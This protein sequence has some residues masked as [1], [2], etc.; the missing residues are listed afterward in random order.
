M[1]V[2]T[3]VSAWLS[4][5]DYLIKLVMEGEG[6]ITRER[7]ALVLQAML[8]ASKAGQ[9]AAYGELAVSLGYALPADMRYSAYLI[10]QLQV[11][12]GARK[13]IGYFILEKAMTRPTQLLEA[14]EEQ[15]QMGGRVGE[16]LVRNGCLSEPQLNEVLALQKAS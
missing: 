10:K 7:S 13:P 5:E 3:S 14:L 9:P 2:M 15:V 8:A 11:T 12:P 4:E 16:I 1:S 6:Y